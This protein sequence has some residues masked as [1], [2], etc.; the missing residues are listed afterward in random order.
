VAQLRR[1]RR[2]G[3]TLIEVMLVMVMLIILA[4]VA[5]PSLSAMYGDVKV[6]AAA[7]QVRASW[8]EARARA[9]EDG[10][11]YRFAVKPG[12]G[13]FRVAPDAAEFWDGSGGGNSA[14]EN[15][16]APHIDE[17]TLTGSI[18]FSVPDNL[19]TSGE[20]TTVAIFN[21]DGSCQ[22]DVEISLKEDDDST[23]IVIRA[24]A[25]TGAIT[26]KKQSSGG[27]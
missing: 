16:P 22:S 18:T 7:D 12:G 27:E 17:G 6:K 13:D 14:N 8:T 3:L 15:Y 4:V 11:P 26:V 1:H 19:P 25:M 20:W 9:I 5:Y 2:R 21:A 10:R 24:R 23:P